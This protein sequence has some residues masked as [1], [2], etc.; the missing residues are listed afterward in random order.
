MALDRTSLRTDIG[1]LSRRRKAPERQ[2]GADFDRLRK[3]QQ[4]R[5]SPAPARRRPTD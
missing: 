1:Y 2:S 3:V 4:R 5:L